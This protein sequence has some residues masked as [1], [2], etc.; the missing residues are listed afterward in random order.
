M[1]KKMIYKK[2]NQQACSATALLACDHPNCNF[3]AANRAGQSQAKETRPG[4]PI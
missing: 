1:T 3:V 4:Q 2:R